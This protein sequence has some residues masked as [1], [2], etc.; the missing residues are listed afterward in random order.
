VPFGTGPWGFHGGVRY[1]DLSQD[2]DAGTLEVDPLLV[3]VGLS[4]RF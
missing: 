3:T 4:Y 1:F 2:T